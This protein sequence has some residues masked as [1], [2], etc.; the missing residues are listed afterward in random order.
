MSAKGTDTFHF[1]KDARYEPY[2]VTGLVQRHRPNHPNCDFSQAHNL[3][4]DVMCDNGK[5]NTINNI[6]GHMATVPE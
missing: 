4:S 5:K 6:A 3:F 1:N 2:R